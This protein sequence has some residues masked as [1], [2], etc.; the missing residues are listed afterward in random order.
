MPMSIPAQRYQ[1]TVATLS[2]RA[3]DVIEEAFETSVDGGRESPLLSSRLH[4]FGM[5]G[6]T[7]VEQ[8]VL[9]GVA[10]LLNFEGTDTM[11]A[12][13]YAQARFHDLSMKL[14]LCIVRCEQASEQH[15]LC[16][17]DALHGNALQVVRWCASVV[18]KHLRIASKVRI[19][20][21]RD[22]IDGL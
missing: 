3:R 13:Y 1:T 15:E 12:A 18:A 11:S 9:G 4:D 19:P 16:I 20:I 21:A 10:H 2:R 5:R 6:C 7:C 17:C 14:T 8:T 22:Q